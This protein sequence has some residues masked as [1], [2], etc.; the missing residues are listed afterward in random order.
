MRLCTAMITPSTPPPFASTNPWSIEAQCARDC[1]IVSTILRR[2]CQK[3]DLI[4]LRGGRTIGIGEL[5][6]AMCDRA[7]L[8]CLFSD[9]ELA[10]QEQRR[11]RGC[12]CGCGGVACKRDRASVVEKFNRFTE[13]NIDDEELFEGKLEITRT[14]NG[15]SF[16]LD[17]ESYFRMA[18]CA[19]DA[20]GMGIEPSVICRL[21]D[22]ERGCKLVLFGRTHMF[23]LR[24]RVS[25]SDT[26]IALVAEPLDGLHC[27]IPLFEGQ[28]CD[29]HWS[30]AL[31]AMCAVESIA[32]YD[33]HWAL[34][35]GDGDGDIEAA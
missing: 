27:Q 23:A 13:M 2:Y 19:M 33:Q 16:G 9:I 29:V 25:R 22:D 24:V 10:E 14:E 34:E 5:C 26:T 35:Q 15:A 1:A 6:D 3:R 8:C 32:F 12:D 28:D 11:E 20:A 17:E 21:P 7:D 30:R 18:R 4:E 31:R